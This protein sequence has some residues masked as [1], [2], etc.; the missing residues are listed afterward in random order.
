MLLLY[1]SYSIAVYILH[2]TRH[3]RAI[4][5]KH[6]VIHNTGSTYLSQRRQRRTKPGP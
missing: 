5:W 2:M 6:D 1:F 4:T 3:G